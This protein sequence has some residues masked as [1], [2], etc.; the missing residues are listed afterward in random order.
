MKSGFPP[1]RARDLRAKAAADLRRNELLDLV[2]MQ[3]LE[4]QGQRPLRPPFEQLRTGHAGKHDRRARRKERDVL[5][6]VQER[7]LAPMDVVEH[8]DER[9]VSGRLLERLASGP[10]DLLRRCL[11]LGLAE[12]RPDY[13]RSRLV[14]REHAELF[15]DLDDGPVGDALAVRQAAAAHDVRV[16]PCQCLV[17][18]PRLADPCVG[19]DGD[20]LTAALV[21]RP[22]RSLAEEREFAEPADEAGLVPALRRLP[23]P[24]ETEGLDRLGLPLQCKWLDFLHLDRVANERERHGAEQ[25]LA[26]LRSLL[27]SGGYVD[28]VACR[29]PLVR[30]GHHLA[31][32]DSDPSLDVEF[33]Q[34]VTHLGSRP[35][36]P[37]GVVLVSDRHAEHRHHRV[38]D[39]LLD[40][41]AVSL[42]DCLHPLEVAGEK[43]T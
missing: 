14:G 36:C 16:E 41:A 23:R 34:R 11:Q 18:E 19:H 17:D 3:R 27:E 30:F 24:Q 42:D 5:D 4:P 7:V 2:R 29:Q 21:K 38:A 20:E 28:G 6:E 26:R 35:H 37:Q 31:C 1:A 32:V 43:G 10:R 40:R 8:D 13:G 25:D 33:G 22:R 15:Q 39:E 12:K 9:P